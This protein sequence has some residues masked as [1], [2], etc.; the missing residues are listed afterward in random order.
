MPQKNVEKCLATFFL[1]IIRQ[2]VYSWSTKFSLK[3]SGVVPGSLNWASLQLSSIASHCV[4][5]KLFGYPT[6]NVLRFTLACFHE[7]EMPS[8]HVIVPS[9]ASD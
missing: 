7:D 9:F 2:T 4:G 3:M 6:K 5:S 8:E 1:Q